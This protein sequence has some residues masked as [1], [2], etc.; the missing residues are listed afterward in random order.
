MDLGR[1]P[2]DYIEYFGGNS[3]YFKEELEETLQ[4]KGATYST[5]DLEEIFKPFLDPHIRRII[6]NFERPKS[7]LQQWRTCSGQEILKHQR[8]LHSF[9]KSRLHYLRCGQVNVGNLDEVPLK[10][11]S[12]LFEKSRDEIENIIDAKE[13]ILHPSE[14]RRYLYAALRLQTYFSHLLTRHQPE[15]L[16]PLQVD[17]HFVEEICK[18]NSD[19]AFFQGVDFTDPTS[20]H[21]YLMKYVILY[22]D[23]TFDPGLAWDEYMQE[24]K[25]R[26]QFYRRSSS[27]GVATM[28]DKEACQC[29]GI[30]QEELRNMDLKQLTR[31]YRKLAK[32]AHPD[33]GGDEKSFIK[34]K[35]AYESLSTKKC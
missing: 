7:R 12:V 15:I 10:F 16:D 6:E 13:H 25:W 8:A 17:H 14:I 33:I 28:G 27:S 4:D 26:H 3:F 22:F 9:D 1:Y 18:I 35:E 30:T 21:P 32:K 31:H 5:D 23:H 34:I 2:G 19:E 11:F 29:L 24:F 20:L